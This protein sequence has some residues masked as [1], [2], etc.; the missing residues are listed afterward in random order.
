[1]GRVLIVAL[2]A[3][4]LVLSAG[5]RWVQLRY[6]KA[7]DHQHLLLDPRSWPGCGKGAAAG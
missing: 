3:V 4:G 6:F 5:T 1:M 7:A 2:L